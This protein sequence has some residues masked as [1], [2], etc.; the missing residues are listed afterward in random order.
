MFKG[1]QEVW[2]PSWKSIWGVGRHF[3]TQLSLQSWLGQV[4]FIYC[5]KGPCWLRVEGILLNHYF[6]FPM[7]LIDLV[8][9]HFELCC[10]SESGSR[11]V[12]R[13]HQTGRSVA[14][15]C[16]SSLQCDPNGIHGGRAA[17]P[18]LAGHHQTAAF[19]SKPLKKYRSRISLT[20]LFADSSCRSHVIARNRLAQLLGPAAVACKL[21][22]VPFGGAGGAWASSWHF[23]AASGH[24]GQHHCRSLLA[25]HRHAHC[26]CC[27]IRNC[28]LA[29]SAL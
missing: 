5:P 1:Y 8:V 10:Q 3:Q 9:G 12:S 21:A 24:I 11:S 6:H 18:S 4:Q 14:P 17:P 19:Q 26:R 16:R 29:Q 13:Q 22:A 15:S 25:G 23:A 28:P 20:P 2:V 7:K 27:Y